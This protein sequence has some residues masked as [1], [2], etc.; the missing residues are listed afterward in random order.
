[1]IAKSKGNTKSFMRSPHL[2]TLLAGFSLND[3]GA[4]CMKFYTDDD[5]PPLIPT[6]HNNGIVRLFPIIDKSNLEA[7]VITAFGE[8]P[9]MSVE[10][11]KQ[12]IE[13]QS[14][15]IQSL[16]E[17][18]EGLRAENEAL[19]VELQAER[20]VLTA[21]PRDRSGPN[22]PRHISTR[23][24]TATRGLVATPSSATTSVQTVPRSCATT[25]TSTM[26]PARSHARPSTHPHLTSRPYP[27]LTQHTS[28]QEPTQFT[29]P[30]KLRPLSVLG[31]AVTGVFETYGI[32]D[33]FHND[34]C[35][36]VREVH[37]KNWVASL[38]DLD[39]IQEESICEL[40]DAMNLDV[41]TL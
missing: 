3:T 33:H 8:N 13:G 31:D 40:L 27:P 19:K 24:L 20:E 14:A 2:N 4:P 41:S 9:E 39:I 25:R 17:I 21:V 18:I 5:L 1:M 12:I 11:A 37:P 7:Q 36:I 16:E 6:G 15:E 26:A 23:G 22:I 28:Y 30:Q 35:T 32:P 38:T 34:I 10:T 29:S